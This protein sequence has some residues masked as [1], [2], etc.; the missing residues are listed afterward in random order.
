MTIGRKDNMAVPTVLT[1]HGDSFQINGRPTYAGHVHHGRSIEG[2]LFCVR[3]AQ[4][5]FD[6]ENW[7][8]I[9]SYD[10]G[11]G[12]RSFAYPDTG[13]WD[14]ERN[15]TEFCAA[16][17][18]W[19]AHGISAVVLSFQGGRPILNVWK[20]RCDPQPWVNVGFERD[21]R[22]KPEYAARMGRCI[23]ALDELGMVAVVG[24]FYFG[25]TARLENDV[26]VQRAIREATEF[27]AG[28]NRRNI[29]IEIAN[30][31]GLDWQTYHYLQF[32]SLALENIH[33]HVKYAQ[34]LC[35]RALPVSASLMA[36]QLPTPDLVRTADLV[37]PHGNDLGPEGHAR[38][39]QYI[40]NMP[41][42]I[43]NPKPIFFNESSAD[44]LDFQAAFEAD[45]SWGYYDHGLNDYVSGFQAPPV[46]WAINT[47]AKRAYFER[48][49]DITGAGGAA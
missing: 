43:E 8:R 17:P 40:R 49:R 36:P 22:L 35:D 23:A 45:V 10:A 34:D 37:L 39:V 4:A 15:L 20:N 14:A 41:A 44:V 28:L 7:P 2:R 33:H 30:E 26:A 29:I 3:A 13:V 25:Q 11:T 5:T 19:K 6:D 16:L 42:Y 31:V 21:G 1:I 12:V 47:Y 46:N 9:K 48:V 27:L 38:K 32:R 18:S 24:Y